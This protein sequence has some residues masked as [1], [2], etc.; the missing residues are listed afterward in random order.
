MMGGQMMG[1]P[2]MAQQ[3]PQMYGQQPVNVQPAQFQAF[4]GSVPVG[5]G[6][7][8]IDLIKDVPLEV[9]VDWEE[10]QKNLL[11]RFL[12]LHLELL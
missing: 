5:Y 7:E 9:T 12:I 4:T 1:Q 3:M 2:M 11:K 8:N 10:L 6:P